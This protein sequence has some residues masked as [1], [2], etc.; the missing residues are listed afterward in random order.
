MSINDDANESKN[1]TNLSKIPNHFN[2]EEQL[3]ILMTNL[4]V[5]SNWLNVLPPDSIATSTMPHDQTSAGGA[6]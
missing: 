4:N 5:D 2:F 6:L 3:V 1:T